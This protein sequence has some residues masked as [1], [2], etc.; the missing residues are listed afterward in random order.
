MG[1]Q[2]WRGRKG[3]R[4]LALSEGTQ[5]VPRWRDL[6]AAVRRDLVELLGRL[7]RGVAADGAEGGEE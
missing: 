1:N 4:Q 3:G 2:T 5:H 7:L 6:P